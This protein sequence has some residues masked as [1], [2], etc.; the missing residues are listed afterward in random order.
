MATRH[1][2]DLP[3]RDRDLA[4]LVALYQ[5]VVAEGRGQ[6]VFVVADEGGGRS[7]LLRALPAVMAR[8]EPRPAVLAGA[9]D[10]GSYVAWDSDPPS[11]RVLSVM[12]RQVAVGEPVASL[13]EGIL[14]YG[15]LLRQV[16]SKSK[17]ALELVERANLERGRSDVTVLMPRV[18][19][20]LCE[21]APVVR[22]V[23]DVDQAGSGWWADLVLLFA[24]RIARNLPLL[25]VLGV[26]GPPQLGP[27]E[28][29]EPDVLFVARDFA[30]DGLAP[31]CTHRP[32]AGQLRR[33]ARGIR[34][35]S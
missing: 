21:D 23:D 33:R 27:H 15:G 6:I 34:R 8:S 25:L 3:G 2:G 32:S 24:R 28:D 9:F 17:A 11:A 29:D 16:L 19:R 18:L 26:A 22:V 31:G 13:T 5:T 7:A 4:W 14:P 35:C 1:A 12:K 30:E 20:R 10:A